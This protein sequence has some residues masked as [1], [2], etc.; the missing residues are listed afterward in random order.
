MSKSVAAS[1]TVISDGTQILGD[2]KVEHDLRVDGY[3]KGTVDVGGVLI[4]GPT[5]KIEGTVQARSAMIAGQI[6]GNIRAL[7]KI[8][9]EPKSTLLGDLQTRELVINEGAVF[10]GNCSMQIDEKR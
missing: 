5:G 7:D 9:M 2:I 4:L 1:Q 10:Q 8:V 3:L 6:L